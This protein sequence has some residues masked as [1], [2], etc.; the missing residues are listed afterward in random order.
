LLSQNT[1]HIKQA[2]R[3]IIYKYNTNFIKRKTSEILYLKNEK[4]EKKET[5]LCNQISDK[6]KKGKI[7]KKGLPPGSVIFTGDN[8]SE[9]VNFRYIL[10]DETNAKEEN[11]THFSSAA[12]VSFLP[13]QTL[14]YDLKGL[15]QVALIEELGKAFT[16]HPLALEDIANVSQRPKFEEYDEGNFIIAQAFTFNSTTLRFSAEQVAF[17]FN[18]QLL[19]SFQEDEDELFLSVCQ[20]ITNGKGKIR[21]R[22]ADYL[23][24][25]LL[26][27]IIDE[28]FVILETIE[29]KI[30]SLEIEVTNNPRPLL[31][32][33]IYQ[34]KRELLNFRKSVNSLREAISKMMRSENDFIE[35]ST[36]VFLRDL[37]D[38]LTQVLERTE[39]SR[40]MLSELQNLYIAEISF[41]ANGVMQML[42]IISSI[43]IP[44]TFIVGLYGM[45]FDVMPELRWPYGYPMVLTLMAGIVIL[46]LVYFRKKRWL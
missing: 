2:Q 18:K 27:T 14:W 1:F 44:L 26:D 25:N 23:A 31:K 19:I 7:L 35:N 40:E 30:T 10:Y 46:L 24:Y 16:I 36:L 22:K 45:N 11:V 39:S 6:M 38:H 12:A 20:Q 37:H 8:T 43:F 13:N 4:K 42:T 33:S 32:S 15:H 34:L 29:E 5:Y 3:Y 21:H 28:Y 9:K 41:K 17:F